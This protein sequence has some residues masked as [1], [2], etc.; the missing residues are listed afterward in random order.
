[1]KIIQVCYNGVVDTEFFE[2]FW[3]AAVSI[4]NKDVRSSVIK[5]G[6]AVANYD[7]IDGWRFIEEMV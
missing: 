2:N 7:P 5:D 4:H 6:N 1:M 3:D